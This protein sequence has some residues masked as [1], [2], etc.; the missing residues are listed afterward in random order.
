MMYRPLF[1]NIHGLGSLQRR[2]CKSARKMKNNFLMLAETFANAS[3]REGLKHAL[4]FEDCFSNQ[5]LGGKL[6]LLW[7]DGLNVSI[8]S[9]GVQ[10]ITVLILYENL[11]VFVS[12]IYAKCQYQAHRELWGLLQQDIPRDAHWL[13]IGDFNVIRSED[14]CCGGRPPLQVAMDDFNDLIDLC[15][16]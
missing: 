3:T 7:R 13:G 6:S 14:E 10:H 1:W 12:M 5:S 8:V 11:Q 9:A 15:G 16:L 4:R 2:L